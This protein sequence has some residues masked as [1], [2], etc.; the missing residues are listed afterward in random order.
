MYHGP[1]GGVAMQYLHAYAG[2]YQPTHRWLMMMMMMLE[3]ARKLCN[4]IISFSI[5]WEMAHVQCTLHC[6]L[7]RNTSFNG[8]WRSGEPPLGIGICYSRRFW[9]YRWMVAL[10]DGQFPGLECSL[11]TI[12]D[13]R[14]NQ[15]PEHTR[16][17]RHISRYFFFLGR[18][19]NL[20]N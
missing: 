16:W 1:T 12:N 17:R 2:T 5:A 15:S 14:L 10:P 9:W 19:S 7:Y 20:S 13:C 3:K 6:C 18:Q 4:V 8:S 11:N